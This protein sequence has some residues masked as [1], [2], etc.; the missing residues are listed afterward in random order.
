MMDAV[1]AVTTPLGEMVIYRVEAADLH[2]VAAL[3]DDVMLWLTSIGLDGQ[4]GSGPL[5]MDPEQ[6]P[7]E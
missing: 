5:P 6:W 7:E 1:D 2:L 3:F 4:W